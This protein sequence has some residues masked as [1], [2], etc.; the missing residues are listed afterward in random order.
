[1]R[2]RLDRP[3][4][5]QEENIRMKTRGLQFNVTALLALAFV[6]RGDAGNGNPS[7]ER[8]RDFV[9]HRPLSPAVWPRSAADL[10]WKQWGIKEKP[11]D[12]AR[13]FRERYGL[14]EAP[15]DN[16]GLPLGLV[17]APLFLSKGLVNNCL[18]CHAG[19]VA[20]RTIIGVG[21]ASLD[22]ESLFEDLMAASG[23]QFGGPFQ[24]G[25]VRG[26]IDPISPVAYLMQLRDPDLNIQKPIVLDMF[27]NVCS[28]P[29]AW[30]LLKRKTTRDWTGGIDARS[31]RIDMANLLN[32]LN[33]AARIKEQ[34]SVFDD[35]HSFLLSIPAPAYPFSINSA[36]ASRGQKI[37]GATCA[38]CHGTYGPG[39]SYPNKI[40][41]PGIIG[42]DRTLAEAI[43]K[44]NL[45]YFNSSWF[46]QQLAPDGKPMKVTEEHGYQAPPLDGVWAMAPY[47]H[48]GSAPTIYHVLNSKARPRYFTRS[49]RTEEADY[50]PIRVGWRIDVL[51]HEPDPGL[52]PYQRR[53]I[54]DSTQPGRGNSGHTFGDKLSEPERMAVI[55]YLKTL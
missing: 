21:N 45:D 19:R 30:W 4:I 7:P 2:R 6:G 17:E 48:N 36:L 49:Y 22:L 20:G 40:V 51:S 42:T 3:W 9:L 35:I 10:A 50:D 5:E 43:S 41:P 26:T 33:S 16:N 54:Y 27:A 15:F 31:T 1:M 34:A 28:A 47:F 14:L 18:L 11:V 8:G 23:Y 53:R 24:F 44:R 39:G 38:K 13:A 12:Y 55:E 37:F 29:P 46:A 32:P 52:P 25:Y